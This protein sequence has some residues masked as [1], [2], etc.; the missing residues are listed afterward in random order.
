MRRTLAAKAQHPT[1]KALLL[2]SLTAVALFPL[3]GAGQSTTAVPRVVDVAWLADHIDDSNVVLL[4]LGDDDAYAAAS[5]AFA[6]WKKET[7]EMLF[8]KWITAEETP[9]GGFTAL[10]VIDS[11]K[12][13]GEEL[14]KDGSQFAFHVR[15]KVGGKVYY[16][17][18]TAKAEADAKEGLDLCTTFTAG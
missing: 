17:Y 13:K 14:V 3:K 7:E 9:D 4:H 11:M 5:K 16:C 12:M 18:G 6:D 10:Y 1:L 2:A 15:K 8:Q